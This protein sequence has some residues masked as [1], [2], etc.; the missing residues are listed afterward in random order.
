MYCKQSVPVFQK[1]FQAKGIMDNLDRIL[2][3]I[4]PKEQNQ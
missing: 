2:A 1:T 3:E 4:S